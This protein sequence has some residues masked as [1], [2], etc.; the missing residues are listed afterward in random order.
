MERDD[1]KLRTNQDQEAHLMCGPQAI[2]KRLPE[3]INNRT[4]RGQGAIWRRIK[5]LVSRTIMSIPLI[6][7]VKTP[8]KAVTFTLVA[9]WTKSKP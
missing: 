7:N 9:S 8:S 1:P 4:E 6:Q 5:T 3:V 2:L